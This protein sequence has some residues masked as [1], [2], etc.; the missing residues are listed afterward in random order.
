MV[1]LVSEDFRFNG[2]FYSFVLRTHALYQSGG[3]NISKEGCHTKGNHHV[4]MSKSTFRFTKKCFF[5]HKWCD[6]QPKTSLA[7]PCV[8]ILNES[9][10]YI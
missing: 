8:V 7:K 4:V 9:V 1:N 10:Q 6:G 5:F 3:Q 2:D